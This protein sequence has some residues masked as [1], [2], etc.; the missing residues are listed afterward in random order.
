MEPSISLC[1]FKS[2]GRLCCS[3]LDSSYAPDRNLLMATYFPVAGGAENRDTARL[4]VAE[5]R[6]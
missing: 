6:A 2:T 3:H 5:S 1:L 4:A